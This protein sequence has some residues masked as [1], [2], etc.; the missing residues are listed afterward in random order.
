MV[1]TAA[2]GSSEIV[3][4][5][6]TGLLV[7]IGDPAALGAAVRRLVLDPELR[8]RLGEA[9]R[10]HVERMFGMDRFVQEFATLYESLV[11]RNRAGR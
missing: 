9:A 6:Q 11:E 3:I 2:G 8:D 5:G 1:A 10:A 4:D 7:P